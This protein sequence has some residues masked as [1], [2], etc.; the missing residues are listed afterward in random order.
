MFVTSGYILTFEDMFL[1]LLQGYDFLRDSFSGDSIIRS[2]EPESPPPLS[3][4]DKH[5]FL[6]QSICSKYNDCM[7]MEIRFLR[8]SATR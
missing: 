3:G 1:I 5:L 2:K 7:N 4:G 8:L 6:Q